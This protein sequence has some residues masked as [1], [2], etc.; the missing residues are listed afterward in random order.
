MF[1]SFR[2]ILAACFLI[3]PASTPLLA[4][5][6]SLTVIAAVSLKDVLE[7]AGKSFT[8]RGGQA[9]R[10]SFV[11]S[12]LA[13]KQIESGLPVD[14][15]VSADSKW[16]DYLSE[17]KLIQTETRSNLLGNSLVFIAPEASSLNE[18]P[19]TFDAIA[20][21]IGDGKFTMSDTTNTASGGYGKSAFKKL[22]LW[23]AIEPRLLMAKNDLEATTFVGRG[24][25]RLGLVYFTESKIVRGVKVVAALPEDSHEPIIYSF[26]ATASAKGDGAKIFIEFLK[27]PSATS[28]FE[29]AGFT[30]FSK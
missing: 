29:K 18:I 6:E 15:Y 5:D 28:I 22:G 7:D 23:D 10:I 11:S 16:M 21:A 8:A 27:T 13:A 2:T 25:A 24:D 19:I 14:L 26:A 20:S 9:V 30:V 4:K 17:K 3:L 12:G 1:C